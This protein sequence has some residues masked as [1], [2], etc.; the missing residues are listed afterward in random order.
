MARQ[1]AWF[2]AHLGDRI[3]DDIPHGRN[4]Y[5]TTN[6]FRPMH[7]SGR[8]PSAIRASAPDRYSFSGGA[9]IVTGH[10]SWPKVQK[11]SGAGA[12]APIPAFSVAPA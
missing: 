7:S 8:C 3:I 12:K 5:V 9:A 6:Y 1:P 10:G 2:A 4:D 11:T